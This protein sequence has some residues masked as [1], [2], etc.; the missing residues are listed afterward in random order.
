MAPMKSADPHAIEIMPDVDWQHAAGQPSW[1]FRT[2]KKSVPPLG[3]GPV[4]AL[5]LAAALS[6]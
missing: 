2:G 4:L 3:M 6:L 5:F 1:L